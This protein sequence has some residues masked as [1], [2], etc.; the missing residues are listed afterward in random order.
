MKLKWKATTSLT[1]Y[2]ITHPASNRRM[3]KEK[4]TEVKHILC[5]KHWISNENLS[6]W[7]ARSM[8]KKVFC[9]YQFAKIIYW[10]FR[11][12]CTQK[13]LL[14]RCWQ[15]AVKV[16]INHCHYCGLLLLDIPLIVLWGYTKRGQEKHKILHTT[17]WKKRPVQ[18]NFAA[19]MKE[20]SKR[21]YS[22]LTYC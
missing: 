15:S 4:K 7:K 13:Q 2:F 20:S 16:Q 1:S 22:L 8:A 3:P 12:E 9:S 17:V 14:T 5:I 6:P 19:R 11:G 18:V 21:F 10:S